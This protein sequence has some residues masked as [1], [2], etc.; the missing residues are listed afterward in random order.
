MDK[1]DWIKSV[2]EDG[3]SLEQAPEAFRGDE[4]IVF[5]ALRNNGLALQFAASALRADRGLA[6]TAVSNNGMAIRFATAKLRDHPILA[7]LALVGD[8]LSLRYLSKNLRSDLQTILSAV[9]KDPEAFR[10]AA[11]DARAD[12][13]IVAEVVDCDGRALRYAERKLRSDPELMELSERSLARIG[14]RKWDS[15]ASKTLVSFAVKR[16][17]L[18]NSDIEDMMPTYVLSRH[19]RMLVADL[20]RNDVH[21]DT[22]PVVPTEDERCASMNG[23]LAGN[24]EEFISDGRLEN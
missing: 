14:R 16:G 12:K 4:D 10:C 1:K 6:W 11:K 17:F 5:E 21:V 7:D 19:E 9:R 22:F 13:S 20:I 8:P 18:L 24:F 3:L 15:E 2:S 23:I